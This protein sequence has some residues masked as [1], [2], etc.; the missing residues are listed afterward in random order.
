MVRKYRR[1]IAILTIDTGSHTGRHFRL[2]VV[3]KETVIS[4]SRHHDMI[5]LSLSSNGY[6]TLD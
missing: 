1:I 4:E 2:R 6:A 5:L 3:L